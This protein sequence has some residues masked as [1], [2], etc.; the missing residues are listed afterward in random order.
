MTQRITSLLLV[1]SIV[2]PIFASEKESVDYIVAVLQV[3]AIVAVISAI[4]YGILKFIR[5]LRN[6]KYREREKYKQSFEKLVSQL[7]SIKNPSAQ[8]SASILLRR[9][10]KDTPEDDKKELRQEAIDV[11]SSLLR[12]QATGVLQKTLADGLGFATDLSGCD[13]QKTN[14]QDVLLDNKKQEILMNKTDLYLSDL[15]F[16]NLEGIKGH[17]IIFYDAILFYARI[18]NCDFTDA[19]FRG[20]DLSG[21]VFKN[22]I[23]K[24]ADFTGARN[25]PSFIEENLDENGLFKLSGMI[26]AKH[27]T[28]G[29]TIFFSMP[30]L[31]NKEDE[32]T[33]KNYKEFLE[34]N[35]YEVIYYMRDDYPR[36]G[37]LNRVKE[38]INRSTGMIAFGFKQIEISNGKYRPGTDD[39]QKWENK[40]L[41]TPWNEIEVG[42]GLAVGMPI[43]LVHDPIIKEGVFENELSECFVARVLSTED[44]RRL[45]YNKSF[46][47]WYS[48][49]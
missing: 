29:K 49:L 30:G 9:Y 11:I 35:G 36:F 32:V 47:E 41:S 2:Q 43:L 6:E 21:T 44:S 23:L 28:R 16:A 22:C 12:V 48:K 1:L 8:L 7:N 31:L 14:L 13:L 45:E 5:E 37:Q 4:V 26:N 10:F 46:Q 15:S 38:A 18:K 40:W 42:I 19:N 33:T 17:G 27:D 25:V 20:A 3:L 34:K 39:E 24:G